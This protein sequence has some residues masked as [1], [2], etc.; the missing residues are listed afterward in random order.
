MSFDNATTNRKSH[1]RP[2]V[3]V[4][5]VKALKDRKDSIEVFFFESN[6]VVL[7]RKRVVI[8][9]SDR[10]DMNLGRESGFMEF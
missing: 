9:V 5:S 1:A 7:Y 3:V 2:F 4:L 8:S 10:V 6:A